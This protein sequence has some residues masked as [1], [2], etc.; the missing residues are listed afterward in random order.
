[1]PAHTALC[2]CYC[3]WAAGWG[4]T[5]W[6][7]VQAQFAPQ[8]PVVRSPSLSCSTDL[9]MRVVR[10]PHRQAGARARASALRLQ[11]AL[12]RRGRRGL[13]GNGC[14][15]SGR[16]RLGRARLRRLIRLQGLRHSSITLRAQAW[17][18]GQ[19]APSRSRK[20]MRR[21]PSRQPRAHV[22][23]SSTCAEKVP[24]CK[25]WHGCIGALVQAGNPQTTRQTVS[26]RPL[27]HRHA[28]DG[29]LAGVAAVDSA[30]NECLMQMTSGAGT[31]AYAASC[32]WRSRSRAAAASLRAVRRR[33]CSRL[34]RRASKLSGGPVDM[35]FTPHDHHVA[36]C[37]GAI[38][39]RPCDAAVCA[40]GYAHSPDSLL[41]VHVAFSV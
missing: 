3:S 2:A 18:E 23:L 34:M 26:S 32:S 8:P 20:K 19:Q 17:T 13:L 12:G 4:R 15:R 31:A 33:S 9:V 37:G 38:S 29:C 28:G 7:Q 1:M 39:K 24:G 41:A 14:R 11:H 6:G 22:L 25:Q 5:G 35:P 10:A 27:S 16:R 36:V 21:S 40:A 30:L